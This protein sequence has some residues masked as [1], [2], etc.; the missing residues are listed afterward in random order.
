MSIVF[1]EKHWQIVQRV[2]PIWWSL[3]GIHPWATAWLCSC[4]KWMKVKWK[5][6]LL[7]SWWFSVEGSSRLT[8]QHQQYSD[9]FC[10]AWLSS[11][12][13]HS[14]LAGQHYRGVDRCTAAEGGRGLRLTSPDRW[15][16]HG[17]QQA[18]HRRGETEAIRETCPP[19]KPI[20]TSIFQRTSLPAGNYQPHSLIALVR[21]DSAALYQRHTGTSLWRAFNETSLDVSSSIPLRKVQ[22]NWLLPD[23]H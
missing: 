18:K 3:Y 9:P 17:N 22:L 11:W 2:E 7:T 1:I 10:G 14:P 13:V 20:S 19:Q 8:E 6:T 23:V 15:C 5:S 12:E 4:E 16:L 21:L